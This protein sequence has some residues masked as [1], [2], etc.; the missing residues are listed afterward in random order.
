MYTKLVTRPI[1]YNIIYF[2][3]QK[4]QHTVNWKQSELSFNDVIIFS[5]IINDLEPFQNNKYH[6]LSILF[7]LT[8]SR[9]VVS[10]LMEDRSP[11]LGWIV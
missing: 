8:R 1:I 5:S 4:P 7:Q 10:N 9:P 3:R 6:A 2:F 11:E